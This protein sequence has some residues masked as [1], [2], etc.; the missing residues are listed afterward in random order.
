M[1]DATDKDLRFSIRDAVDNPV[2]ADTQPERIIGSL[3]FATASGTRIC[4]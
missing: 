3:Q 1:Q 4:L 2:F